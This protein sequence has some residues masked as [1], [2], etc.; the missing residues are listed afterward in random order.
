[1]STLEAA[2]NLPSID[3]EFYDA[4][5]LAPRNLIGATIEVPIRTARAWNVPAGSIVRLSTPEGPQV[6]DLSKYHFELLCLGA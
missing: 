6:G 2:Y 4:L 3:K 1:M 5:A